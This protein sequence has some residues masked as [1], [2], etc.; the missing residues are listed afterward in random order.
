[1]SGGGEEEVKDKEIERIR[2]RKMREIAEKVRKMREGAMGEGAGGRGSVKG[3]TVIDKPIEV[4]DETFEDTVK[5]YPLFVL[6]CW[7]PWCGPCRMIAPILEE[8]AK[9]YA[10]RVVFGKLNVDENPRI[11]AAF[12]IMAIPTLLIF[13]NGRLIDAIQ[14]AAPKRFLEARIREWL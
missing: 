6:D 13:K 8:L 7:A 1:M 9:E 5:K 3:G 12:G 10:G 14:G 2:E 4:S 11:A